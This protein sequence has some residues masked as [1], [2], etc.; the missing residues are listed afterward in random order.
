MGD[1][2][3]ITVAVHSAKGGTGKTCISTNLAA[4]LACEGYNV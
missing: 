2:V 1:D 3:G 4:L